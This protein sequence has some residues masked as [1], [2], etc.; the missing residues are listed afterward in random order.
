MKT[1]APITAMLPAH[2]RIEKTLKTIRNLQAC[3]PAPAEILV[4]VAT[5]QHEMRAALEGSGSSVRVLVS[6]ANL[7]PGGARNRMI[8]A[9][10]NELVASFDDDSYPI[11]PDFFRNLQGWFDQLPQASV[12]LMNIFE[13]GQPEPDTSGEPHR[14][15]SFVGCGCAYRRTHFLEGKGYVPI[16][17]AY[18][19]EEADLSIRYLERG[20][21]IY[22]VP[23][24]RVYHDTV[25]SHHASARVAGMQVANT[26]LFAFLRYPP[27]R[28][29]LGI[30]QFCSKWVDTIFRKRWLGALVACPLAIASFWKYRSYRSTVRRQTVDQF[31]ELLRAE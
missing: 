21:E 24:L 20:R 4:H 17:I 31:R 18:A 27:S 25:L 13:T 11:D 8:E 16:P 23:A 2:Q 30:A 28:W 14:V 22:Y 15:G 12:L 9:A 29:P 26:A 1:P 6:E 3:D 5:S 19:M 7:G 10:G